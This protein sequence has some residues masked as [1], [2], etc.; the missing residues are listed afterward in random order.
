MMNPR[1]RKR[2]AA[3]LDRPM[4]TVVENRCGDICNSMKLWV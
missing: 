4:V 2:K 1:M 3:T